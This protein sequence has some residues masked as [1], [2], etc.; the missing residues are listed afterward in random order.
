MTEKQEENIKKKKKSQGIEGWLILPAIGIIFGS[1]SYLSDT[2]EIMSALSEY[3]R[4]MFL[5]TFGMLFLYT[6]TAFLYFNKNKD[7]PKFFI[8]TIWTNFI[9]SSILFWIVSSFIEME[10]IRLTLEVPLYF[11]AT[12]VWTLYF[13][14]SKRVKNTFVN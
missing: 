14:F 11:V 8:I 1:I 10:E 4:W 12:I 3:P 5:I 6:Y 13:V 9:Y 7:A 2:L